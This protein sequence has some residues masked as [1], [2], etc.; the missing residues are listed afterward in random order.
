MLILIWWILLLVSYVIYPLILKVLSHNQLLTKYSF[1]E[2]K[3]SLPS[4]NIVMAIHNEEKVFRQKLDSIF[5]SE[6]PFEKLHLIIGLDNCT[7]GSLE[8]VRSYQEKFPES[9]HFLSSERLGKPEMLNLLMR[10]NTIASD[11]T[12]LT[13]ANVIFTTNTLYELVKFFKDQ[14]VGLVDSKFVLS[15]QIISH[16]EEK[17]Y[18]NFEQQLKYYEGLVWGTMQGPFG[19]CYAIRTALYH[20][21]P[22]K[23]LVDDF[24]IGMNVMTQGFDAI[25]N[26]NALVMEEVH[27]NWKDEFRRKKRISAGNYQNLH[28]FS[29]ILLKPF[30][31]LSITW[32]FHKVLRWLLPVFLMPILILNLIGFIF[33]GFSIIPSLITLILILGVVSLHYLLQRL[34][35]HSRTIE[36]LSYFI[37]INLALVQGFIFYIKGIQTNVWKPT[38]R[39]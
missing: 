13:D 23:F 2:K 3:D 11:I 1:F 35:L 31:A 12:I 28:F 34:N 26:P 19:A 15:S 36:R 27:T 17:D 24:F 37:Y 25:L 9:I 4:I 14:R 29:K 39:K 10:E 8:I 22:D 18:L 6:Y 30:T 33:W 5:N 32:F 7:D 16:D 20:P 21:I 38:Q